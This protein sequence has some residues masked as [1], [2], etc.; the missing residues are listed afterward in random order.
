L[1]HTVAERN[2]QYLLSFGNWWHMPQ[3]LVPSSPVL[4]KKAPADAGAEARGAV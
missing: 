2:G 1:H 3:A 4:K